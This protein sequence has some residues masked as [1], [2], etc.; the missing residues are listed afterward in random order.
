MSRNHL[1]SRTDNR[2]EDFEANRRGELTQR[3]RDRL[4]RIVLPV[5]LQE[6]ELESRMEGHSQHIRLRSILLA[7]GVLGMVIGIGVSMGSTIL[8][9]ALG[10][11]IG[12]EFAVYLGQ[13]LIFRRELRHLR[14]K[15]S[16]ADAHFHAN[17]EPSQTAAHIYRIEGEKT[18]ERRIGYRRDRLLLGDEAFEV[19]DEDWGPLRAISGYMVAHYFATSEHGNLLLSFQQVDAVSQIA[20]S[21]VVGVSDDGEIIY[22]Q[23]LEDDV[24]DG[25][26]RPLK[27]SSDS[28]Q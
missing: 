25:E 17:L 7:L 8:P 12:V 6:Y 19:A 23:D 15:R 3:Q 21:E 5:T 22:Q 9:L 4:R 14:Q 18:L 10:L 24:P 27:K 2:L 26:V 16:E 13:G 28:G 20:L 11:L 1:L